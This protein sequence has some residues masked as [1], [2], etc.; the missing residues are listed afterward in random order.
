MSKKESV[1]HLE[2]IVRN[3]EGKIIE[4]RKQEGDIYLDQWGAIIA[5]LF[6]NCGNGTYSGSTTFSCKD[7]GGT[8]RTLGGA[9]SSGNSPLFASALEGP[10]GSVQ[11]AIGTGTNAAAHT[12]YAL[13]TPISGATAY[14]SSITESNPSGNILY[15][16]FSVTITLSA[17]A[18][19]TE[20]IVTLVVYDSSGTSRTLAITHD[21]FSAVNVPA[22]GSI[23]LNYTLQFN[24]S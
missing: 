13:Q 16:S 7:T 15:V 22:S 17:A 9:A 24:S 20:A 11:V 2:I 18:A 21:V 8:A 10:S 1:V 12:D 14:P 5:A 6:K 19:V 3:K 4:T 23:T